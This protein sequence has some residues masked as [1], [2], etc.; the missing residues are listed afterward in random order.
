L[1]F[2]LVSHVLPPIWSGQSMVLSR[3]LGGFDPDDYVLIRTMDLPF[4]GDFAERLPATQVELPARFSSIAAPGLRPGVATARSLVRTLFSRA[5]GIERAVR[6]HGADAVVA[7]TGGDMLDVP[8]GYIAARRAGVRFF[9]YFFDHWSQQSQGGPRR[10]RI[11]ERAERRLVERADAVIV[12]NELLADELER[13]YGARTAIVRNACAVSDA[14]PPPR[15]VEGEAA[16]V[17]TGAVYAANH[18]AFRN[19]VQALGHLGRAARVHVYTA[20]S[21]AALAEA[22]I[23]GPVEVHRHLPLDEMPNVHA[24][25][26]VLFLPLAFDSPYPSL[27]RSS[28]PGKMAEYLAARKPILV[29]APPDSFVSAYFRKHGCGL[30][31]EEPDPIALAREL[32]RL[33]EDEPLRLGLADAGRARAVADY[34]IRTARAAFGRL[35]G[36]EP[37][38]P[39]PA[40][41]ETASYA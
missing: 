7:C 13:L 28:N 26:D 12:P 35:V 37:L 27:I 2:A 33:L 6:E 5:R 41:V 17:Y 32:E 20:Q 36:V 23:A 31:V 21:E 34:D 19:L 11:A 4:D 38:A 15:R 22:G 40:R 39:A 29:H 16:I 25:A 3:L 10:R 1:G 8:A 30:V 9:P 24:A 14:P 18:D